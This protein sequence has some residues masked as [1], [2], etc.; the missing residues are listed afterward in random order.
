MLIAACQDEGSDV[1]R[2]ARKCVIN[3]LD[4]GYRGYD[5]YRG[6]PINELIPILTAPDLSPD[7]RYSA[8][9][10][11][12]MIGPDAVEAVPWL[13]QIIKEIEQKPDGT[14]VVQQANWAIKRIRTPDDEAGN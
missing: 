8:V 13:E 2:A 4:F 12:G 5:D 10:S 14:C 9:V 3:N 7:Q 11:L 6:L 1:R